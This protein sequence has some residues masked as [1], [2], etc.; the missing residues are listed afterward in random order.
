MLQFLKTV[1]E[2]MRIV[3]YAWHS[4]TAFCYSITNFV[5]IKKQQLYKRSSASQVMIILI[6]VFKKSVSK[7]FQLLRTALTF[8]YLQC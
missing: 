1:G 7:N 6:K 3:P 5:P 8:C 2:K 4:I